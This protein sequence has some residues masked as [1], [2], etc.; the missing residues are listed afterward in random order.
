M[1]AAP[2]RRRSA[3]ERREEILR[4]AIERFAVGGYRGTSTDVI[5]REAG[6]S[7]AYLFRLFRTKREL[8]L[9]CDERACEK[10][11]EMFRGAAAGAPPGEKLAARDRAYRNRLLRE[12]HAVL[13]TMQGFAAAGADPEIR[14]HVRAKFGDVV[15]EV[16]ELAGAYPNEVWA[17]FANGMLLNIVA[18]LEQEV[19]VT[20]PPGRARSTLREFRGDPTRQ[21]RYRLTDGARVLRAANLNDATAPGERAAAAA[22][23][24]KRAILVWIATRRSVSPTTLLDLSR[25]TA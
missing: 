1:A 12:R 10:V 14:R 24:F 18:A 2:T 22:A 13:M 7:Q 25:A 16:G 15:A 6:I 9:A 3:D 11:L 23:S 21:T 8:F 5:A 17:F 19:A 4:I 20:Q